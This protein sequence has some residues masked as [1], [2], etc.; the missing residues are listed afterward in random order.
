ME[1]VNWTPADFPHNVD[2]HFNLQN[3]Q[4]EGVRLSTNIK[5][6]RRNGTNNVKGLTNN[7]HNI[8]FCFQTTQMKNDKESIFPT[9]FLHPWMDLTVFVTLKPARKGKLYWQGKMKTFAKETYIWYLLK[10]TC[11]CQTR[12]NLFSSTVSPSRFKTIKA[13]RRWEDGIM[14]S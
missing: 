4:F 1:A 6:K 5:M 12:I 8:S 14:E 13:E 3:W 11:L 7:L 9:M 10:Y 2:S